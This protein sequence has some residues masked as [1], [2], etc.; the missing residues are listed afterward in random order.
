MPRESLAA[1]EERLDSAMFVR[2]NRSSMVNLDRIASLATNEAGEPTVTLS[3][4]EPLAL[5]RGVPELQA[6]LEMG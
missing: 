3:T 4:G 5:T 2:I 1:L 6:R